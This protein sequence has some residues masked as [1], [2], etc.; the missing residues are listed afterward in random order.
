MVIESPK[1]NEERRGLL[2]SFCRPSA[3]HLRRYLVVSGAC[4]SGGALLNLLSVLP[5]LGAASSGIRA[6]VAALGGAI[7][8]LGFV[9]AFV[10]LPRLLVEDRFLA[11]F[12][13]ELVLQD[14][15]GPPLTVRW[16]DVALVRCSMG[17][18][19]LQLRGETAAER[20]IPTEY[21]EAPEEFAMRLEYL[22]RRASLRPSW[23]RGARES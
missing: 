17:V 11:V 12:E 20:Q 9:L 19:S 14:G 13:Q 21:T 15:K 8:L 1:K 4:V 16:E 2:L 7:V 10:R 6:F 23:Q 3:Q 5:A 18:V 22:R